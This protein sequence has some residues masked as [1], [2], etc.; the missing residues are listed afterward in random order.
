MINALLLMTAIY[1]RLQKWAESNNKISNFQY[2]FR[3]KKSTL[4]FVFVFVTLILKY[5]K[6]LYQPLFMVFVDLQTAFP[7]IVSRLKMLKKVASMIGV[8]TTIL[9]SI[10]SLRSRTVLK[11]RF[12]GFLSSQFHTNS[13]VCEGASSFAFPFC[14]IF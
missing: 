13:G 2:G 4:D 8:S 1:F 11:V 12:N 10:A 14:S 7:L 6:I 5:V 3:P 9:K